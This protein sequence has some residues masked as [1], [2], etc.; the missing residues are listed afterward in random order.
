MLTKQELEHS[1]LFADISYESYLLMLDCFHAV[2]K[3][4]RSGEMVYDFTAPGSN[5][6]GII[7][8]GEVSLIRIGEEGDSTVL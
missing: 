1:P 8:R 2:Q 7:E 4:F 5:A 6:V 3:S